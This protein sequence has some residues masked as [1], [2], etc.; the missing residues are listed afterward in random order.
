M[1]PLPR[2][3][4]L[5]VSASVVIAL[6]YLAMGATDVSSGTARADVVVPLL[7]LAF[8]LSLR[9]IRV[10]PNTELS[11]SDVAV[12][13][14]IVLLPPGAVAI[15]AAGAR[16]L[17]DLVTRKR[18]IQIVRNGAAVTIATGTAAVI[19]RIVLA[20]TGELH[21]LAA[22]TILSGV[23]AVVVLVATDIGQI[24]LLQR[25][26]KIIS[27]DRTAWN[28]VGRTVRAQL[29]W[30]LA[31][32]ITLQVVLIE[33]WF[34]VP[35]V[36]LFVMGY[37]DIR[38][39]FAAERRARLLAV[40]VEV[41]HAVGMSLDPVTVFREVFAQVKK[42]LDVD[43]FY[44]ASADQERGT[45]TF[46]Y[47]YE[48]GH[49]MEP[50]ESEIAGTL[51]GICIERD[52][53]ILL[54]DADKDRVRLRLPERNAWGT[55]QERSL[56]VAPLRLHG[57]AFGA[58]SVQSA[59]A[60]AYDEG[61]L[62]LLAAI[63]NEAAIAIERA[64]LYART[65]ALSRRLF[66]LHRFGVELSAHKE[67]SALINA[68]A[69]N[70]ERLM[71]AAAVAIYL[72]RG[73][74]L[75]LSVTTGNAPA[76]VRSLPKTTP[77][78]SRVVDSGEAIEVHDEEGSDDGTRRSL[79]RFGHKTVF[80][81]PLRVAD[82]LVGMLFITWHERH[83]VGAEERELLGVIAGIG[84]AQIRGIQLYQELDEGYLS[85]V[86][87]LTA[88]ID[89]RDQYREDHQRRV[90][91][92]ALALGERLELSTDMQRDLRYASLFHSIGKI[93]VPGTILAKRG[94]LTSDERA[95]V[96]EHP[97]LGARILES[98]HFLR[99]VVPI[100]RA[101]RERWDGTGYPEKIAGEA[102]PRAA[103]AL[104]VVVDYH[105]MLV[106]RPYRVALRPETALAELR[107]LAGTW[108]DPFIVNEFATMIE[109]RG[110]IQAVEQE[111][112]QTN[113]ELAIL[114]ELTPE[115]HTI[116]DLQQLLDRILFILERNNPGA[117]FTILLRDEKTDDLV[118]RASA[119]SW[120]AVDSPTRV[121]A[122]R[123]ISSW[124]IEHREPQNIEDVRADPRY[125][126]D[127]QVRSELIV[128]LVSGGRAIGVLV[129][130]HR[131]VG[132]FSQR[133]LTLMQTVGAQIAAAIDVAGLHERLKRAANTD[134]LTGLH[135]YRYFFDRLEEEIARAE[136]RQAPLAVAFFDLDKLKNVNDTYGH[137]AGNEVLRI[138]GQSI[139][140]HV[141][142][143]DVPA[144]YG[145]DEFAIVMPDTP[146]DEA[147]KVVERLMEMLDGKMVDL[148]SGGRKIAMPDLSWGVA[149]YPLDGRTAR[150][151]VEN[152]DTRAYARKRSR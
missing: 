10:Q 128:P 24:V 100:V 30:S 15:V 48:N 74:T 144:R 130:S 114:A 116:L 17:T 122:G 73:E 152:A 20:Q 105:A 47:L 125:V 66:D 28:W 32:V 142:T 67:L 133:D 77:T 146:R 4:L 13:A 49:E 126:G 44:V 37:M 41:G 138:L 147:E 124:V 7:V 14:G 89:A 134:A 39:R 69:T 19:Y 46:R 57:K 140:D 3:V 70:V 81:Q 103:R 11:P 65:T 148:P 135:N 71:N 127:T 1:N 108:Y 95:I 86:G 12:L 141:R 31:A 6:P 137:L 120:T 91:A 53:P 84:A 97:I 93:A 129:L 59:R 78:I 26:L 50:E 51:A 136:R 145:G 102:I 45:L 79:E 75:D 18:P 99:G 27:F 40:L 43:A 35:G 98:I 29:L 87:A 64:D 23:V 82:R 56:I 94:P 72:D 16:V 90:A 76:D 106:D 36:P 54:R 85:T 2:A 25:A 117:S 55:L 92:D 101:G 110:A 58:I 22:R 63:G 8:V 68:F 88:T 119:G 131:S 112:G 96:E 111:V 38:A 34:L 121:Q 149:S 62:E 113:R 83:P 132:A 123:G 143:E 61:D 104:R 42:T 151:L 33:P 118:V 21:D 80:L 9:P 5:L 109:A 52:Q 107:R 150:E 60:N 139:S 115:F